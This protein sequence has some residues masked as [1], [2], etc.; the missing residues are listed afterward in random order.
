MIPG[1][2]GGALASSIHSY[3]RHGDPSIRALVKHILTLVAQP[4]F[5]TIMRWQYDGDLEDT[6]HEVAKSGTINSPIHLRFL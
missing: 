6:Y 5:T 3:I 1:K 2:K 4:I